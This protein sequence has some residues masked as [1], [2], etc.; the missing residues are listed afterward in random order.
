MIKQGLRKVFM[1]GIA[2]LVLQAPAQSVWDG[3]YTDDQATRGAETFNKSCA[4][5]HD[6]KGEFTGPAFMSMWK[7]QTAFDLYDKMRSEMPMDN[8]GSLTQKSYI[9]V[10]AFMFKS[11][12]F[13]TGSNELDAKDD[14]LKQIK[15]EPKGK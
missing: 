10:V 3:V 13:P 9:D 7:G 11:N 1:A 15:I 8:P 5:C 12:A 14:T 6:L 2:A 4:G